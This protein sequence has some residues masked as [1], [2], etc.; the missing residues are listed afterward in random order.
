MKFMFFRREAPKNPTFAE[1]M[2]NLRKAGFTVAALAGGGVRV[3]RGNCA[4]DLKDDGGTVRSLGRAGVLMGTEIG[5]LVDGGFQKFF[6]TPGGKKRPALADDL[7]A[8][9]EFEEDLKEALGQES[10]YNESLGTVSTF[11]LYD[12]VKDRDHGV[13]KRAWEA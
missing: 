13:P 4:I 12:R 11:Y 5:A 3:T 1:R 2:E 8:L 10:Y 6:R 9:H 7:K